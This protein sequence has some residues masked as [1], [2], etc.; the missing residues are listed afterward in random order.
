M[1]GVCRWV[2]HEEN[3]IDCMTKLKGN[4]ARMLQ[5]FRTHKHRLVG[6]AD[7]LEHRRKYREATRK[8]KTR[9]SVWKDTR[10]LLRNANSPHDKL[11]LGKPPKNNTPKASGLEP[12]DHYEERLVIDDDPSRSTAPQQLAQALAVVATAPP[13][14]GFAAFS[15]AEQQPQYG[16]ADV[17]ACL[18]CTEQGIVDRHIH[19]VI[20]K[21]QGKGK[22]FEEMTRRLSR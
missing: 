14:P 17:C 16:Y 3:P 9:L 15:M 2:P 8:K 6:E 20:A 18:D 4:A 22:Q 5:M 19:Q 1:N 7:E 11:G 21:G 10:E 12:D 13:S